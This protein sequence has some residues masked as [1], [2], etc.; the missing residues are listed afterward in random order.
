MSTSE[1]M[2]FQQAIEIQGVADRNAYLETACAGQPEL[3]K[4]VQ[5]LLDSWKQGEF[6]ES[7]LP[8]VAAIRTFGPGV[9]GQQLG[10]YRIVKSLGRGGMGAVFLAEQSEPVRR[11]VAIKIVRPELDSPNVVRRFL[12]EQRTLAKMDHPNIAKVL[13]ASISENGISYFVMELVNGIPILEFCQ[14]NELSIRQRLDLFIE[15]CSAI[16]HAHQNSVIHRDIKPSNTLV[17]SQHGKPLVKVIDFGIAKALDPKESSQT[18]LADLCETRADEF[19]GTPQF[20]SPEQASMGQQT[21]DTR[22]DIYS[23]GALLYSLLTNEPPFDPGIMQQSK[24]DEVRHLV[25]HVEP[26]RPSLRVLRTIRTS[27]SIETTPEADSETTTVSSQKDATKVIRT[28]DRDV[29]LHAQVVAGDLDCIVMKAME[30]DP[31]R[32]Y[33]T[34]VELAD[35]VQRYL[36]N[37][38]I[39]ARSPTVFYRLTKFARRSRGI[40][41]SIIVAMLCLISGLALAVQQAQR[42]K[43]A[44]IEARREAERA[45]SAE[46]RTA[47]ALYA[48]DLKLASS[49]TSRHN[50][51]AALEILRRHVP[52]D[53]ASD[54]RGFDWDYLVKQ[55]TPSKRELFNAGS[56]LYFLVRISRTSQLACCGENGKLYLLDENTGAQQLAIDCKQGEVNGIALSPDES[57]LATAG[58][59][60]TIAYW[61]L[62]ECTEVRRFKAHQRQAFQ[63][64]WSADSK[65]IVS[66]GNEPDVM[67]W[68]AQTDELVHRVSTDRDLECLSSSIKGDIAIG[69]EGG[70]VYLTKFPSETEPG[71]AVQTFTGAAEAHCSA[72]A[73]SPDGRW[74]ASAHENGKLLVHKV[75]TRFQEAPIESR[76]SEAIT[77]LVFDSDSSSLAAGLR[78]GAVA[79]VQLNP[80]DSNRL[81]LTIEGILH[82][83]GKRFLDGNYDGLGSDDWVSTKFSQEKAALKFVAAENLPPRIIS[84][85]PPLEN[86][87]LPLNTSKVEIQFSREIENAKLVSAYRFARGPLTTEGDR[88]IIGPAD[89]G[90]AGNFVTLFLPESPWTTGG[91]SRANS[92]VEIATELIHQADVSRV[93]GYRHDGTLT[94]SGNDGRVVRF[95][96]RVLRGVRPVAEDIHDLDFGV[97]ELWMLGRNSEV[98]SRV[99]AEPA[100]TLI[101]HDFDDGRQTR[102][103]C[104]AEKERLA[105]IARGGRDF[106]QDVSLATF[107]FKTKTFQDLDRLKLSGSLGKNAL[108]DDG[109]Y[110]AAAIT[111]RETDGQEPQTK[112]CLVD[113]R[114]AKV[115]YFPTDSYVMYP[116][117]SPCGDYLALPTNH[118]VY[119]INVR[120]RRVIQTIGVPNLRSA[121]VLKYGSELLTVSD[122]GKLVVWEVSTGQVLRSMDAHVISA[123]CVDVNPDGVTIATVGADGWL[124]LWRRGAWQMTMEQRFP[125]PLV[126][127]D[128][129]GNGQYLGVMDERGAVYV[130]DAGRP[131]MN[132]P[133]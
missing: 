70:S 106:D 115:T 51:A 5:S 133:N 54:I 76:L 37:E 121:A 11:K 49:E 96:P 93:T 68:S 48:S 102:S 9:D 29:R 40:L 88:E 1:E 47:Q 36:C 95:S 16:Q 98:V 81:R 120:E 12:Q 57:I 124:R 92:P 78:N 69:A 89:I 6:L 122:D 61:K 85:D 72:V 130:L 110:F 8:E 111:T 127:C 34:V 10:P 107:D 87:L 28:S 20:M 25:Q 7:T 79:I 21:I 46:R 65:H 103:F 117:F 4:S 17:T 63:V 90:V 24:F 94:S 60:G 99:P 53:A 108:S 83:K 19:L 52:R 86:G 26:L 42:A 67:I 126:Y 3:L 84:I 113:L 62:P 118:E 119:V 32:R 44:E 15:C 74:L 116:A 104:V 131:T 22:T 45:Q 77:S 2:I 129:S 73:F 105:V 43:V 91:S 71:P 39:I 64:A 112:A 125:W 82:D 66:C 31:N 41:A 132:P 59:D 30:K 97:K 109:H 35:D 14:R 50:S 128:F 33:K 27:A 38:P 13:D 23:L 101:R 18:D 80:P 55:N 56:P 75:D 123:Q 100:T 114:T 58:D